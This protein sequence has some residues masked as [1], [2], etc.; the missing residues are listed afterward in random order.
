MTDD[1]IEGA[2]RKGVGHVQD[3]VGGLT[4]D[5]ETQVRGKL[6]QAGGAAQNVFG[7]VKDQAGDVYAEAADRAQ[8][9]YG[10]LEHFIQERPLVAVG[11]GVV[12]GLLIGAASRGPNK[13]VYVRR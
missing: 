8:D 11:L 9:V 1:R 4:G 5:G 7:K 13:T 10:E 3:A 2:L 12:V 6:N